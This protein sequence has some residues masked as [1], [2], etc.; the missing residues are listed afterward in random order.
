MDARGLPAAS[1]TGRGSSPSRA[2]DQQLPA[3]ALVARLER[4][5]VFRFHLRLA[6]LLGAGTLI[7]SFDA[8][9]I[10][11]ALPV[12]VASFDLDVG[13]VGWLISAAYAGQLV[14]SVL[15]GWLAEQA[16]RRTAYIGSLA[17]MGTFS[18]AAALTWS[19]GSLAVARVLTG[20]GLGG[21][22]PIAAA[23]FSE[24]VQ[25]PRRGFVT[26]LWETS[27]IWGFLVTPLI[28]LGLISALG[29]EAGWRMLFALGGLSLVAALAAVRWLPESIRW[30][31][32]TGRLPEADRTRAEIEAEASRCGIGLEPPPSL[33]QPD[34]A[35]TR[36]REP[37]EAAYRG[38][39]LLIWTFTFATFFAVYGIAVWLPTLYVTLGGL[40][41]DA[42]LALTT[43]SGGLQLASAYL[44]ACTVDRVGRR[45]WFASGLLLAAVAAVAGVAATAVG[46]V[47]WPTLFAVGGTMLIGLTPV[48]MGV[49][50]YAGEMYPTRMRAWGTALAGGL[51]RIAAFLAPLAVAAVLAAGWGIGGVFLMF[52]AATSVGAAVVL[53]RAPETRQR[54]LEEIAA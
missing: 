14:G 18:L 27:F 48:S 23:L 41:A 42:A 51:I 26:M 29:A 21:E 47:S 24:Y 5:P 35:P 25:A 52:A 12:I 46:L 17:L 44:F 54:V 28:A 39:T 37:L 20:I 33:P 16:G 13:A 40:P 31:V 53:A 11:V 6:G 22:V 1:M 9:A 50:L 30:Q 45:R 4:L 15:F 36:W 38:R 43:I 8:L 34:I 10:A 19:A 3:T 2:Q 49:F 7:D 32:R